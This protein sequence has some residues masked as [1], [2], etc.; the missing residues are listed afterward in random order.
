MFL[1]ICYIKILDKLGI[2]CILDKG[3]YVCYKDLGIGDVD[4]ND[5]EAY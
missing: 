2:L 4:K 1:Q 3:R 5:Y